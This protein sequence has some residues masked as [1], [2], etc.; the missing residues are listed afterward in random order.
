LASDKPGVKAD[1]AQEHLLQTLSE[2]DRKAASDH[3]NRL[4]QQVK[5]QEK[6]D[7]NLKEQMPAI[8]QNGLGC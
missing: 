7:L 3:L 4:R 8:N 1:P 2:T 5:T 6:R